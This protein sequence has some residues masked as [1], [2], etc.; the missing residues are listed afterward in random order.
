MKKYI[1]E[2]IRTTVYY[3]ETEGEDEIDAMK[4]ATNFSEN[5]DFDS[6]DPDCIAMDHIEIT[7]NK[8]AVLI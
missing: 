2:I 3:F 5:Y 8:N 4:N 1:G 6:A 7:L